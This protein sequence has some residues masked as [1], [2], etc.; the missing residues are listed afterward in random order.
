MRKK[1]C[2]VVKRRVNDKV[3]IFVNGEEIEVVVTKIQ[4]HQVSIAFIA[5]RDKVAVIRE[6][7]MEKNE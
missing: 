7:A 4:E 2:L 5:D 3:F 6:E 1:G